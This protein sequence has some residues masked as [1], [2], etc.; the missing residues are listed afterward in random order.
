M[1]HI[2]KL[3]NEFSGIFSLEIWH[4]LNTGLG[5]LLKVIFLRIW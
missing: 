3:Y 4:Q 2:K 1:P 5:R